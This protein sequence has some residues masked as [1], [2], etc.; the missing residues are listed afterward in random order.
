VDLQQNVEFRLK[1]NAERTTKYSSRL[2]DDDED[3]DDDEG[4]SGST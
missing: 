1:Q 2:S 4:E 3:D